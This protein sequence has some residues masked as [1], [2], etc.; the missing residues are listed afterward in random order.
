MMKLIKQDNG[1]SFYENP[2]SE[3]KQKI[4][5]IPKPTH[6]VYHGIGKWAKTGVASNGNIII[7]SEEGDIQTILPSVY[8]TEI[9]N[10]HIKNINTVFPV[11]DIFNKYFTPFKRDNEILV[12]M[13]DN[14]YIIGKVGHIFHVKEWQIWDNKTNYINGSHTRVIRFTMSSSICSGSIYL[15]ED[16]DIANRDHNYDFNIKREFET[17]EDTIER[18]YSLLRTYP[19]LEYSNGKW[20][21][22]K[23]VLKI[24][25]DIRHDFKLEVRQIPNH[26]SSYYIQGNSYSKIKRPK[27]K[28]EIVSSEHLVDAVKTLIEQHKNIIE[29]TVY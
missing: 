16:G 2:E 14:D 24:E 8:Y 17:F 10:A 3:I 29:I 13:V 28:G 25:T 21:T 11:K 15:T 4:Q 20:F 26:G 19:E 5:E 23:Y 9:H 27:M 18:L 12:E 6:I 7:E 1:Y 22:D